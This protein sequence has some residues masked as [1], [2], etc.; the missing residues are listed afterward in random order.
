[1]KISLTV[2]GRVVA[3]DPA[4]R[5]QLAEFL[6]EDLL[7]TGTHLGCEHGVCGACTVVVN[8]ETARSCITYA[9]A[10]DGADVRTIEG[11]G[12][13]PLMARLREAFK[14][15]HALQCGYCT[16]GML[17]AARDLIRRKGGLDEA[18][19][20]REMSGNL[21]RCTGYV[22][23]V[24]AIQRVMAER[25]GLLADVEPMAMHLGPLPAAAGSAVRTEVRDPAARKT[26]LPGHAK[27]VA[28][29]ADAGV[30]LLEGW[31]ETTAARI[32]ETIRI[33][34]PRADVSALMAD[35]AL[36]T[37]CLPGARL[38]GPPAGDRVSGELAVRLGPIAV[39]FKGDG[40]VTRA[41]DGLSGMLE[42]RARDGAS[43]ARG[44]MTYRLFE[45]GVDATR[46]DFDMTYNLTGPLAQ[47]GRGDLVRDLVR[48]VT[49]T[50]AANIEAHIRGGGVPTKPAGLS[51]GKLLWT[52]LLARVRR[53]LGLRKT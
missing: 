22:G 5:T 21:C 45:D 12:E 19:I 3:G 52:V 32:G 46:I 33:A 35:V 28:R 11:F 43:G 48:Q 24:R 39:A 42:G 26:E 49:R 37:T 18:T 41:P 50:F 14:Q 8:G 29:A 17:I 38:V 53:L 51:A 15:D 20:R 30:S 27:A 1:M 44:R 25:D 9:V 40:R 23:I 47:F 36:L 16:P 2:N 7:L 31:D 34:A 6:R 13:D 10:C 4:P